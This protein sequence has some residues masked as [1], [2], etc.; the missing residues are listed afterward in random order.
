MR[1][2]F[3]TIAVLVCLLATVQCGYRAVRPY[4]GKA[5]SLNELMNVTEEP[6]LTEAMEEALVKVAGLRRDGGDP[7]IDFVITG[8]NERVQ[9][10]TS[11]GDPVRERISM[12]FEWRIAGQTDGAD[13]AGRGNVSRT[14]VWTQDLN[15]LDWN[16]RAAI[17]LLAED[18]AGVLA[19]GIEESP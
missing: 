3:H 1:T 15:V 8:F 6:F 11:S 5:F 19:D 13:P 4:S 16:R 9:S 2:L 17:R 14:Y 12:T 7:E 10:V 18:A